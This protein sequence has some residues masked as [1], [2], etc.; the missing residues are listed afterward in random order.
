M[1]ISKRLRSCGVVTLGFLFGFCVPIVHAQ[2][3]TATLAGSVR[4]QAGAALPGVTLTVRSAATGATRTAT[5]DTQ[6]RCL[7]AALEPGEWRKQCCAG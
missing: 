7:I 5:T 6:G 1:S 3:A 4:D 2:I